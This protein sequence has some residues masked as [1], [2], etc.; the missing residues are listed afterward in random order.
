MYTTQQDATRK[1]RNRGSSFVWFPIILRIFLDLIMRCFVSGP[2][3]KLQTYIDPTLKPVTRTYPHVSVEGVDSWSDSDGTKMDWSPAPLASQQSSRGLEGR[4]TW[5][6]GSCSLS[7]RQHRPFQFPALFSV[8][9]TAEVPR[10]FTWPGNQNTERIHLPRSLHNFKVVLMIKRH[11]VKA[12]RGDFGG[13][14]SGSNFGL[15]EAP[16]DFLSTSRR[17]PE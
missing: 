7:R 4:N 13:G 12:Y 14:M 10:L 6:R 8:V 1:A 15:T 5:Y 2:I 11:A 17:I 9:N 3:E 16:L